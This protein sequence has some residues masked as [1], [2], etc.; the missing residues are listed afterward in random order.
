MMAA[1]LAKHIKLVVGNIRRDDERIETLFETLPDA[2][3]FK[4]LPGMG[5]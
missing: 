1:T 5:P 3:L 4:S 2:D